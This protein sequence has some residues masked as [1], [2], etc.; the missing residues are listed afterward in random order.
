MPLYLR[1]LMVSGPPDEVAAAAKGH[2]EQLGRLR[3]AGH[4]RHAGEFVNGDGFFEVLDLEDRHEAE[5]LTRASPL[6]E[7]GL[8]SWLLRELA[9]GAD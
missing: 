5:R 7:R 9:E 2:V 4:L 8:T 1:L 3:D 6:V